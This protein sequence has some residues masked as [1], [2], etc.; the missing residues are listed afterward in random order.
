MSS[1]SSHAAPC[2]ILFT[3]KVHSLP[4]LLISAPISTSC[5]S[6]MSGLY[7]LFI[8]TLYYISAPLLC[9]PCPCLSPLPFLLVASPLHAC[10]SCL[11]SS[12]SLQSGLSIKWACFVFTLHF[13]WSSRSSIDPCSH[14]PW[15][16]IQDCTVHLSSRLD[17]TGQI[18]DPLKMLFLS[19]VLVLL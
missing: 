19:Y 4:C 9:Y 6:Y 12:S 3:A 5:Q 16:T 10:L 8:A 7:L 14:T 13:K 17:R 2:P 15:Y 11:T 1:S 18:L